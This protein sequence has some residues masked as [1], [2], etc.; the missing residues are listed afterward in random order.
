MWSGLQTRHFAKRPVPYKSHP[1]PLG[2]V[3]AGVHVAEGETEA[4]WGAAA[5]PGSMGGWKA[6]GQREVP[7]MAVLSLQLGDRLPPGRAGVPGARAG[8]GGA[9][10]APVPA[11]AAARGVPGTAEGGGGG[12]PAACLPG[13]WSSP[14]CF[15]KKLYIY[16][17]LCWVIAGQALLK[18]WRAGATL[19][20]WGTS[21]SLQWFLLLQSTGSRVPS[22]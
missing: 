20:L 15:K 22:Q 14:P 1:S 10:A 6:A 21:F 11:A 8:P 12:Q 19:Y 17:W 18:L 13:L 4:Q 7:R 16:F 3:G 5:C 9:S 2:R